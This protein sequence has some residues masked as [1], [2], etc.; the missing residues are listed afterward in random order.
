MTGVFRMGLWGVLTVV[1]AVW[2][3]WHLGPDH[4]DALRLKLTNL[5]A[6]AW[7]SYWIDYFA[8]PYAR[9]HTIS[10]PVERAAA[11]VRRAIIIAAGT[12]TM[13]LGL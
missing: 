1:S 11:Y 8:F 3:Y 7:L 9:P 4:F 5:F 13:G 10:D 6:G 2:V 12:L